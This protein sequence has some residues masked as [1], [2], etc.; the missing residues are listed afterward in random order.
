MLLRRVALQNVRSFL[1]RAELHLEGPISIVIGPNG[2]GKTNL[3]DTTVIILR[4]YMFASMYAV[5]SPTAELE[6][7]YEFRQ[8]DALNNMV[9]ERHSQAS[10][11]TPQLVEIEVEVTNVDVV[12]MAAMK[13]DGANLL[14]LAG[15]KYI[16]LT[17]QQSA[18]W[19]LSLIAAGNRFVY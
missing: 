14:E 2:G 11:G 18:S 19:D 7:R 13:S 6:N 5:H 10:P 8:N 1:D 12:N 4:R 17:L 9:L 16:N 15:K 3:L